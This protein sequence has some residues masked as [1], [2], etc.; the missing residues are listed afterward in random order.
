MDL[1]IELAYN[2]NDNSDNYIIFFL[3]KDNNSNVL[4]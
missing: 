2:S 4:H 3:N 1:Q